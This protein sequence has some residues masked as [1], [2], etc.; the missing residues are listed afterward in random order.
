M[1]NINQPTLVLFERARKELNYIPPARSNQVFDVGQGMIVIQTMRDEPDDHKF[2]LRIQNNTVESGTGLF[3][4]TGSNVDIID[5]YINCLI[6][7]SL[8]SGLRFKVSVIRS[9]K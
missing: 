9:S 7:L 1:A 2:D 5:P 4:F 3:T 8:I 6:K